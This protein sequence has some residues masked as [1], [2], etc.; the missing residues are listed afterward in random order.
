MPNSFSEE[1][2]SACRKH[3]ISVM[4][5]SYFQAMLRGRLTIE[6]YYTELVYLFEIYKNLD[7]AAQYISDKRLSAILDEYLPKSQLLEKDM[8]FIKGEFNQGNIS[9]PRTVNN[10]TDLIYSSYKNN[11]VELLSAFY[12]FEGSAL[13]AYIL[14]DHLVRLFK[15]ENPGVLF[16]S[17]HNISIRDYWKHF[18]DRLNELITLEDEKNM[19]I[20]TSEEIFVEVNKMYNGII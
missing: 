13:G 17:G 12:V 10:I 20:K 19:I 7:I 6:N 3:H 4:H 1:I 15:F 2:K 14:K 16:L 9:L 8:D 11:S 5:S 18:T